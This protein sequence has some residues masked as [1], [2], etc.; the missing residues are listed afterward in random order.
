MSEYDGLPG[1]WELVVGLE[2]HVELAT[3]TKLFSASPNRFGDEP[4]T[5][6]DPVTLGLPGA[7]PVLNEH[8]VELA[9]RVGLALNCTVQPSTFH[10]K[11]YFYPDMPKAYQVTQYDQPLNVDG[12][13]DLPNGVRIGI[14]RAHM[15]EDAGKSTH[16]GGTGG[17]VHGANHSLIDLNRAGVPLV[18][19]VSRPD[20]RS[21]DDARAYVSELRAILVVI[22]ASDAKMEEGSMRVDANVSVRKPGTPLGTR[23]EIKNVN[24]VR[25]VGRAIEYEARRQIDLIESG[26]AVRQQTRHWDETDGRT[27]TLRTKEDADDYRYFLE[28]DLV[29]LA[30]SAEWI[31]RVRAALPM[32]PAARRTRLSAATGQAADSEAVGSVVERGQDDYVLTV[33]AAGGDAAR[34]LVHVK[35]AFADQSATPQVPAADLAQLTTLEL[36]GKLTATQAKA[37]L[38]EIVAHNGGDANVIAAA[39]GFEA[40]DT[41][42]LEALVDDAIAADP[43]AWQKFC[44]G[45]GKAMGALVGLV[46]KSSKGKADGKLVTAL[47]NQ[48]KR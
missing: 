9:M 28:P 8:A 14:E 22:G 37:V 46:M 40:M 26:D 15:E 35:E 3:A 24:S 13:L 23:C 45:D 41:S 16:V 11:N 25:S 36:G 20:I 1:D 39:K 42:S 31:E 21:A 10:R 43:D 12:H 27:H 17:R 44:N 47:L 48:K 4:N 30:P 7:L 5:N 18:E 2:V 29:P 33:A 19:I 34:A 6:I 38:A 32:L